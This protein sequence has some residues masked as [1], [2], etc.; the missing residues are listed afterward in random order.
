M[1]K[2][3][4]WNEILANAYLKDKYA[5]LFKKLL[6]GEY[7][8]IRLHKLKGYT[9]I[10]SI[11]DNREDR[12][13]AASVAKPG[14]KVRKFLILEE[15]LNHNYGGA[16]L[17]QS[18][19]LNAYLGN[20]V[21]LFEDKISF[22]EDDFEEVPDEEKAAIL[23]PAEDVDPDDATFVYQ[24][25]SLYKK[26]L[27]ELKPE[28]IQVSNLPVEGP[29]VIS[30]GFG[31]GKTSTCLSSLA[32]EVDRLRQVAT[33]E[34]IR[35]LYITQSDIL[36][37][38][39]KM[40]WHEHPCSKN[41]PEH[42]TIEFK[43]YK[44]L[45]SKNLPEGY[46]FLEEE[47]SF[48]FFETWFD[49][50]Y[51][52]KQ[53]VKRVIGKGKQKEVE[54]DPLE[55][56]ELVY[57]EFRVLSGYSKD[58][59]LDSAE[60]QSL[61]DT[62]EDKEWL[63]EAFHSYQDF[64][65]SKKCR[66][67]DF[68]PL[69]EG[70]RFHCVFGDETQDF[71]L[72][73]VRNI[74]KIA[75]QLQIRF[76]M[77]TNQGMQIISVREFILNRLLPELGY[78]AELKPHIILPGCFRCPKHTVEFIDNILN[79]K[80]RLVRG[81]TDK[82]EYSK[83]TSNS[84]NDGFIKWFDKSDDP[85]LATQIEELQGSLYAV[86]THESFRNEAMQRYKT[87]QVFTEKEAKGL[88]WPTVIY[89]NPV[90]AERYKKLSAS[91]SELPEDNGKSTFHRFKKHNENMRHIPAFN[92]LIVGSSRNTGNLFVVQEA[93]QAHVLAKTLKKGL[94]KSPMA[95]PVIKKVSKEE[96]IEQAKT[97]F[98]NGNEVQAQALLKGLNIS[99][100]AQ[101]A[102]WVPTDEISESVPTSLG[103]QY[104]TPSHTSSSTPLQSSNKA[105]N[106]NKK[107]ISQ[108]QPVTQKE[109]TVASSTITE[110][111]LDNSVPAQAAANANAS[112]TTDKRANYIEQLFDL[113][114]RLDTRAKTALINLF[115]H[116]NAAS[117]LFK[118]RA[119]AKYHNRIVF[120]ALI[121]HPYRP[122][123]IEQMQKHLE[124]MD[125][126]YLF[127][128]IAPKS[129]LLF[130]LLTATREG[131]EL[132]KS[133]FAKYEKTAGFSRIFDPLTVVDSDVDINIFTGERATLLSLACEAG[134]EVMVS[135]LL[136][137]KGIN[138]NLARNN[139]A[140]PLYVACENGHQKIVEMLL[141][142]KRIDVS[143]LKENGSTPFHAACDKGH[144]KIVEM[145][146]QDERIQVN[147]RDKFG[148]TAF[149]LA[150]MRGWHEIVEMILFRVWKGKQRINMNIIPN[151]GLSP[152][153]IACVMGKEKVVKMLWADLRVDTTK[154]APDG[155]TFFQVACEYG[156]AEVLKIFLTDADQIDVNQS[157]PNDGATGF[158]L[159][160]EN[161]HEK[162]VRLLL[163]TPQIDVNLIKGE[164]K[165][166]PFC[167]ACDN[168]HLSVIEMLLNDNRVRVNQAPKNGV[169]PFEK[170]LTS[171]KH[172]LFSV[173]IRVFLK[174]NSAFLEKRPEEIL[175]QAMKA[176][177][178]SPNIASKWGKNEG[179]HEKIVNEI[180]NIK[181]AKA[182]LMG[183][184]SQSG[185]E[186][187]AEAERTDD[188]AV[189]GKRQSLFM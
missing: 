143:L 89:H 43:T 15:I 46:K 154:T 116:K 170:I 99:W 186:T 9:D 173:F 174:K 81:T 83:V 181:S 12:L 157:R 164:E 117:L 60:T 159:A 68:A 105:K 120:T 24:A 178:V 150:C 130:Q 39:V 59:Y 184:Y 80:M 122:F 3:L 78:P 155:T 172:E 110:K 177:A 107:P 37:K 167:I 54:S 84:E 103:Q 31:S 188:H 134:L 145:L 161:G 176:Y 58:D 73:Q 74:T 42:I 50:Y 91:F 112:A 27:L 146:L 64:L 106:K 65:D 148:G 132:V 2:I 189:R 187:S 137:Y 19:A 175:Q 139:G 88:E 127:L 52:T 153:F 165:L 49:T 168:N 45:A 75:R 18:D 69:A 72:R 87:D 40:Y 70:L 142:D 160:C 71:S 141:Q 104:S 82:F 21:R 115:N 41:V 35:L 56:K 1:K 33:P 125:P 93:T 136:D 180:Q 62:R 25:A 92:T 38:N 102:V 55:D 79:A 28:Q 61:F 29:L 26:M 126:I 13:L 10:Y 47:E 123:V 138:V 100:E 128:P 11:S 169:T 135:K 90:S 7:K 151:G 17:L 147:Q 57:Q 152:F 66:D 67:I 133:L 144:K 162:V 95:E 156:H 101:K 97:L 118:E 183:L 108:A 96:T 44:E 4:Y 119:P 140:T 121:T 63:E 53:R 22:T 171:G 76:F 113:L 158:Y 114:D 109:S 179:L 131:V 30:G 86:I 182:V 185:E 166:T 163:E 149:F 48:S 8:G 111:S 94:P 14:E 32:I 20:K 34:P 124:L 6:N 98:F 51:K 23:G 5:D 77:D 129:I 36:V 85:E 16:T